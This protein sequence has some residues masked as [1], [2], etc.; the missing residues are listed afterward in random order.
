MKRGVKKKAKIGL[1]LCIFFIMF[2]FL[3]VNVEAA[4]KWMGWC[5][6]CYLGGPPCDPYLSYYK[7]CGQEFGKYWI[8]DENVGYHG[9]LSYPSGSKWD[10]GIYDEYSSLGLPKWANLDK[11]FSQECNGCPW[12][13]S[14][15]QVAYKCIPCSG[16]K[17]NCN[18]NDVDGCEVNLINDPNNCG[19]CGRKCVGN[20]ECRYG[21]CILRETFTC[22]SCE[23]CNNKLM[24]NIEYGDILKLT[25]DLTATSSEGH[26]IVTPFFKE[27]IIIDC[28]NHHIFGKYDGTG[29][30]IQFWYSGGTIKNCNIEGFNV[31]ISTLTY[32][33][34]STTLSNV[35]I[36]ENNIGIAVIKMQYESVGNTQIEESISCNNY[37]QDI[38]VWSE[39]PIS[40]SNLF[41]DIIEGTGCSCDN[42]CS[43]IGPCEITSAS[44]IPLDCNGACNAGNSISLSATYAISCNPSYL[45][46]EM[47]DTIDQ[48]CRFNM[49]ILCTG[50]TSCDGD[51]LIPNVAAECRGKAVEA[52]A[53]RIYDINRV[54]IGTGTADGIFEFV[55]SGA[56][57]LSYVD[58]WP[59]DKT[60]NIDETITYHLDAFYEEYPS[61][62]LIKKD[63][64]L[65]SWT[66][67]TSS[68]VDVA[69]NTGQEGINIFKGL[70]EGNTLIEGAF[71]VDLILGITELTKTDTTGLTIDDNPCDIEDITLDD[72]LCGGNG[73]NDEE[74]INIILTLNSHCGLAKKI[75]IDAKDTESECEIIIRNET[76]KTT[77][78]NKN[79]EISGGFYNCELL[80]EIPQGFF[81]Q[82]PGCIGKTVNAY[83]AELNESSGE[84]LASLQG[85]I[86]TITF[87]TEN[88]PPVA[89]II[90]PGLGIGQQQ[91]DHTPMY[92]AGEDIL[93]DEESW[94]SDGTI[95]DWYW[96]L[97]Y[98]ENDWELLQHYILPAQTFYELFYAGGS[99][100]VKLEVIDDEGAIG[101]NQKWF[102]VDDG[103]TP[104][105][106]LDS[107]QE[108]QIQPRAVAINVSDSFDPP[109]EYKEDKTRLGDFYWEFDD[110]SSPA[111]F[112]DNWTY[113][114]N[115]THILAEAQEI[116]E[117]NLTLYDLQGNYDF[118]TIEFKT[119]R[120]Y[121]GNDILFA[122]GSKYDSCYNSLPS[123][124]TAIGGN[125]QTG[126]G[127]PISKC[128]ICGCPSDRP[129]C[130]LDGSCDVHDPTTCN[131]L[132]EV[133]CLQ[134][135]GCWYEE[136]TSC[137]TNPPASCSSYKIN[138]EHCTADKCSVGY[139]P[140]SQGTC[141]ESIY[142][143]EIKYFIECNGCA[144]DPNAGTAGE[145]K[146]SY[147]LIEQNGQTQQQ[148]RERREYDTSTCESTG[149]MTV[150]IITECCGP[151]GSGN[152][153]ICTWDSSKEQISYDD[154]E[155]TQVC[156]I[157]ARPLP[158][159][160]W[161]NIV[162]IV[163]LIGIYY[164]FIIIKKKYK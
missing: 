124:C 133:L 20:E 55:D 88:I 10:S 31:G 78:S 24:N 75:R 108:D 41:C 129:E 37:Q 107:P 64:T 52:Y 27:N 90:S 77:G 99:Y 89:N 39:A 80:W 157:A 103:D 14:Q 43:M 109:I 86:G 7:H 34:R 38:K 119:W 146:Q 93:F 23:D 155:E 162:A 161:F 63:V 76:I 74:E 148:C 67:Y 69:S 82:N 138:E 60:I 110:G 35:R 1:L 144:W 22:N 33:G 141:G 128:Q 122:D 11:R 59:E 137:I 164:I 92:V 95:T 46:I 158:G 15:C 61:N 12:F 40:C 163:A 36:E 113:A 18:E 143:G 159:F 147:D 105:I 134:E 126:I 53:S 151:I 72:S 142:V 145:C 127:N 115:F 8:S 149:Y 87:W 85:E 6:G 16:G 58:L 32:V 42:P 102:V 4:T 9:W 104:I 81:I 130:Q 153:N 44:A 13:Y 111:T 56:L 96:Y 97:K 135:P 26:C 29:D 118:K 152:G 2:L 116:Y 125:Q 30:G 100:K 48:T 120:C 156:G 101:T 79:C 121:D 3:I 140:T 73:C 50:E 17:G 114:S 112:R 131:N 136:C 117:F 132:N 25:D 62:A 68:N 19:S 66:N 94:D 84:W 98:K 57:T 150:T 5:G 21:D 91:I 65:T 71:P 160:S 139:N 70:I 54:F 106:V 49:S 45:E 28:D 47:R 51:W 154:T 83:F 123:Y